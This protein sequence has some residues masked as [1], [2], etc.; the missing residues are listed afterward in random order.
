MKTE[1]ILK[2]ELENSSTIFLVKEGHFWRAF[3]HSAYLF[4]TYIKAY[5]PVKK[6][7]KKVNATL[8]YLGFPSSQLTAILQK[9]PEGITIDKQ[10]H[11]ISLRGFESIQQE[12]Y[13]LWE[14]QIQLR[15]NKK[16]AVSS[17]SQ[18]CAMVKE[19]PIADRTPL[20][21]FQFLLQ[22]KQKINGPI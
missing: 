8:V 7:I 16:H 22:L 18:I 2:I 4:H 1:E 6:H 13:Q 19:Y 14:S 10:D 5:Q 9:I 17:C 11:L 21:S 12:D 20:E 3:L 15:K